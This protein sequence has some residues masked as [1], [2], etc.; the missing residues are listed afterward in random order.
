MAT[1]HLVPGE[2]L[3]TVNGAPCLYRY[4]PVKT[5][6]PL[7]VL[8]PGGAHN[9]RIFYGGHPG[10]NPDD[11]LATRLN[12]LGYSVLAISYPLQTEPEIM[13]PC[14]PGFRINEWGQQAATVAHKII[15]ERGLSNDVVLASWS[16]GGRILV[17]FCKAARDLDLVV[18][19]FISLSATPGLPG[20]RP[21]TPGIKMTEAGYA[22]FSATYP[23]FLHQVHEQL[24]SKS[25]RPAFPDDVY[26]STYFGHTPSSLLGYG[27]MY[28][29]QNSG[30]F[31]ADH[32]L[33]D[34]D[35]AANAFEHLPWIASL[36]PTSRLD[37][38]HALC[39]KSTWNFMLVQGLR[40]RLEKSGTIHEER[41][42]RVRVLVGEAQEVL[43]EEIEGTHFFFLG[44]EGAEVSAKAMVR[45]IDVARRLEER[46]SGLLLP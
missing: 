6:N 15:T 21:P 36:I 24:R 34:S 4:L 17:P 13:P 41:W 10:S 5:T 8:I 2:Q 12:K 46:L 18:E 32:G 11:F 25:D 31:V 42:E 37:A 27:W 1:A 7:I 20:I 45:M 16:M 40:A 19:L 35:A 44:A 30:G 26:R 39:D 28:D 3:E 29:P 38:R 33:S 9:A 14:A 22:D 43:S 23:A